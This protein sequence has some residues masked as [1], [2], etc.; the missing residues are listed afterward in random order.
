MVWRLT[1]IPTV[2]KS[3]AENQAILTLNPIDLVSLTLHP[4]RPTRQSPVVFVPRHRGNDSALIRA[5]L[6]ISAMCFCVDFE[7]Y[8]L[9]PV[10]KGILDSMSGKRFDAFF[11]ISCC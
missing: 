10:I 2:H 1:Y 5:V 7:M 9:V 3:Q 6:N 8:N 11:A 4:F